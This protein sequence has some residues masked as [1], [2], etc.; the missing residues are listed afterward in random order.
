MKF[1]IGVFLVFWIGTI[2]A[3]VEKI[4]NEKLVEL[5][6]SPDMQLLDVRTPGEVA[7]GMIANA[8]HINFFDDN[9]D[10][11]AVKLDKD[12]PII[13]YCAAGGRSAKSGAKLLKLGFKNVYDLTGGFSSWKSEGYP[14]ESN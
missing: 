7:K 3:Q 1:V 10:T 5:M 14:T 12:K 6:K 9:F 2:Q 8:R 13:V 11:E 4:G